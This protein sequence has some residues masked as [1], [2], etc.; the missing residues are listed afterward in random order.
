MQFWGAGLAGVSL[1]SGLADVQTV[2]YL[3]GWVI[4]CLCVLFFLN[5][6]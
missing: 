4:I 6:I 5:F 2:L 1:S 3:L